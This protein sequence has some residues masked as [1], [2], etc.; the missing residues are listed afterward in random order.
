MTLERPDRGTI[1]VNGDRLFPADDKS[2]REVRKRIGMVFRQ[3]TLFPHMTVLRNLTEA[4][5][6]VLGLGR[7]GAGERARDLLELVGLADRA[8]ARPGTLSGGRQQRVA[9]ARARAMRPKVL[10]LDEVTSALAPESVARVLDL[11]R[12]VARSADITMVCVPHE[13]NFAR[14]ISD[15]V[16][17]FDAGR[18]IESGS[19]ER[20]LSD[21]EHQRTRE[22]LGAVL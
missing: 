18:V 20:I 19:P 10:L 3:F 4:P 13:M 14:D 15:E 11:L 12:D 6:R 7:E 2:R 21:P 22:F 17:M 16:L 5:V 9:I 8:V 1:D